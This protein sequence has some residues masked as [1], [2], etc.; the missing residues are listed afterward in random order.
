M[1]KKQ[2]SKYISSICK[3]LGITEKQLSRNLG[4]ADNGVSSWKFHEKIPKQAMA[5]LKLLEE[6]IENKKHEKDKNMIIKH[7]GVFSVT[8]KQ[9]DILIERY[10][11]AVG[12]INRS[13][14]IKYISITRAMVEPDHELN[15]ADW[16]EKEGFL[17]KDSAQMF[18]LDKITQL[19]FVIDEQA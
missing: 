14:I 18:R 10:P 17:T 9:A 7:V 15:V 11:S 19:D 4:Y 12:A 8:G 1:N 5:S 13:I 16:L 3:P 6:I 2:I